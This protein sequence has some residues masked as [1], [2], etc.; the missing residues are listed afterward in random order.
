MDFLRKALFPF[1]YLYWLIVWLRDRLFTF[2]VLPSYR[3]KIPVICIGNVTVGGNGKSPLVVALAQRFQEQGLK[4][5]IL[6]RGYGGRLKGPCQVEPS[7][8]TISVGDEA[9]MISKLTGACV[10]V[11]KS[12]AK[13]ARYIEQHSLGDIIILDDG[14]QHRWLQRDINVLVIRAQSE[15]SLDKCFEGTLLPAGDLREPLSQALKRCNLVVFTSRSHSKVNRDIVQEAWDES[16]PTFYSYLRFSL[17]EKYSGR[18]SESEHEKE[19]LEKG[20]TVV[21]LSS[22]AN[23][24]DFYA[25][26]E[27]IGY[28][29]EASV[30]LQDHAVIDG[31]L[32]SSIAHDHP[33]VPIVCT[34]KD[35]VKIQELSGDVLD[36][37]YFLRISAEIEESERFFSLIKTGLN[38][39][40]SNYSAMRSTNASSY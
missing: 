29:I 38:E 37:V 13:G 7:S 8:T 12:R 1:S 11:A 33:G 35:M 15:E 24:D 32:L 2:G 3:S 14:L 20:S 30:R 39:K 10:V 25:S 17:A 27:A 9:L 26:L 23:P 18:V 6:T 5:V 19:E 4:P 16:L 40:T 36:S 22:I 31:G 34:D 21:A 28:E